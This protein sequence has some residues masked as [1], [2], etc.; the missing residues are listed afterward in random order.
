MGGLVESFSVF[1][2][3]LGLEL[4]F[5]FK[6][7]SGFRVLYCQRGFVFF[8]ERGWLVCIFTRLF[9]SGLLKNSA[10]QVTYCITFEIA[11]LHSKFALIDINTSFALNYVQNLFARS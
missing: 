6:R 3:T 8:A 7:M 2:W 10:L 1:F 9:L 11:Y 5:N 4:G